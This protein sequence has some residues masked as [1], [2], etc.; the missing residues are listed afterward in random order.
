MLMVSTLKYDILEL[1]L[2][3]GFDVNRTLYFNGQEYNLLFFISEKTYIFN[4]SCI[5][6]I[7]KYGININSKLKYNIDFRHKIS[8]KFGHNN[9]TSS[10]QENSIFD[11]LIVKALN[12]HNYQYI[13]LLIIFE[14]YGYKKENILL[15]RN[16][17][18]N[19]NENSIIKLAK[20]RFR[21]Y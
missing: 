12:K 9:V 5:D 14:Y 6:L 8:F 3:Y 7:L 17:I 11:L 10:S 19:L 4:K 16:A 21:I 15:L 13:I 18:D 20:C 1:F 2:K